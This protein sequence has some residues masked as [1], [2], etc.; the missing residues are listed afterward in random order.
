[1]RRWSLFHL[2]GS[3]ERAQIR[4]QERAEEQ[5]R[6]RGQRA[7]EA[8][9]RR[10]ADDRRR[11]EQTIEAQRRREAADRRRRVA[12]E[13]ARAALGWSLNVWLEGSMWVCMILGL[14]VDYIGSYAD[15][16]ATF[17]AFGYD[18]LVR[19]IM[20]LGIDLPAT[21]SVLGQLLAG[22][23]KCGRW[24]HIRLGLL[25]LCTAPLTLV[26]NALR[27]AINAQGH[28]TFEVPLWQDLAA[29]AVP[30]LGVVVIGYVASMMQGERAD[31]LRRQ[32]EAELEASALPT[33]GPPAA[34]GREESQGGGETS[35]QLNGAAPPP[36]EQ[37][38]HRDDIREESQD[39]G[40]TSDGAGPQVNGAAL[41][42]AEE[43][44]HRDGTREESQD[45]R[46]TG[47][48]TGRQNDSD[49]AEDPDRQR[50]ARHLSTRSR[51]SKPGRRRT[52]RPVVQRLLQQRGADVTAD[53]VMRRTTV[54]RRQ[55]NRLLQE[56]R[57]RRVPSE[58]SA[59]MAE[60][61]R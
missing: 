46:G 57:E 25:T 37:D 13:L 61:E 2:G 5:E 60:A 7:E 15:L 49:K 41:P 3:P 24:V 27:G 29:F 52:A 50:T 28:F 36:A 21:A 55:A 30:G 34:P 8:Q 18:G 33:A 48:E 23:W 40:G 58:R 32:Y 56:E 14:A 12:G 16:A 47:D 44:E 4:T 17:G 26:G 19:W 39:D 53:D 1:M 45:D 54:G 22:R 31:L 59:A 35:P 42:S 20:P 9:R 6:R 38:E 51:P 43:D 10:E 11:Q